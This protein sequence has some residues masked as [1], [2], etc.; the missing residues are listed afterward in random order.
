MN[1]F[2]DV[3]KPTVIKFA[4]NIKLAGCIGIL[5]TGL[6]FKTYLNKLKIQIRYNSGK[7]SAIYCTYVE[8]ISCPHTA[9]GTSKNTINLEK[10]KKKD[11]EDK[12]LAAEHESVFL[13][14]N[15]PSYKGV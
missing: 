4:D 2:N 1:D 13:L 9:C 11:V 12:Q 3:I 8:I 5:R 7:T 14:I 10:K 6:K 15:L